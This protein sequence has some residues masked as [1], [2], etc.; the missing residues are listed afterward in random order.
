[1]K[2]IIL[3]NLLL[4]FVAGV[5]AQSFQFMNKNDVNIGGSASNPPTY[6]EYGNAAD[7]GLTKFHVKN[8]SGSTKMFGI[9]ATLE[10]V[11]NTFTDLAVCFGTACYSASAMVATSQVINSGLGENVN[12]GDTY[13]DL[14]LAPVTWSWAD[15][16]TDST[17]WIVTVF[18]SAN[19]TDEQ[20]AR[21]VWRDN[22][23]LTSVKN[24]DLNKIKLSAYPN[25][26]STNNVTITYS[27]PQKGELVMYDLVGKQVKNYVLD[28][29]KNQLVAN[30]SDLNSGVYFYAVK[31]NGEA[32]KT[33][34]LIVK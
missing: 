16:A 15:P 18:D 12:D 19:P 21:I 5:T 29:N 31:V 1:M 17:V 14:K 2:K 3:S 8:V 22:T 25:P 28:A 11:P 30:V 32:I 33:E 26:A 24:I 10:Y 9:A 6:Y 27:I 34:R 20:T 13:T 23:T 4:M 7:L